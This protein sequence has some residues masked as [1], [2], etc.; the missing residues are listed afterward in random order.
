MKTILYNDQTKQLSR[1]YENGYNVPIPKHEQSYIFVLEVIEAEPKP[2]DPPTQRIYSKWVK[3]LEAKQYR[4]EWT[5]ENKTPYELAMQDW[6]EPDY[7]KR[8]RAPKTLA[9]EYPQM[10]VWFQIN[11]LPIH[12]DGAE[13]L[14]YCNEILAEHQPLV[15]SLGSVTVENRPEPEDFE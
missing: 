12:K 15:D 3:D 1:I 7:S 2:Y 8:I 13:A 5:V 6:H 4:R 9:L 14:L 11:D 10:Y